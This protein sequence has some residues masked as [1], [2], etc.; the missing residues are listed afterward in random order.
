M[1]S[2]CL[3]A[4]V[5][6][7]VHGQLLVIVEGGCCGQLSLFVVVVGGHH[8]LLWLCIG[9]GWGWSLLLVVCVNDQLFRKKLV[10]FYIG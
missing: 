2:S 7:H 1:H 5:T 6:I 10:V 4:F 9:G 3:W 8:C